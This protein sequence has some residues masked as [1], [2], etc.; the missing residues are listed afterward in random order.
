MGW[1]GGII[2]SITFRKQ[3]IGNFL[4]NST[5][6]YTVLH[7]LGQVFLGAENQGNHQNFEKS[8]LSLC[9]FE[10]KI[11]MADYKK[12]E[13]STPPIFNILALKFH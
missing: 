13:I 5:A 2:P 12:N 1:Q 4:T 7:I 3:S 10:K 9:P 8:L 11:K 6:I